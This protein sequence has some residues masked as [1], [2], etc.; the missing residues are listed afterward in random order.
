MKM[1]ASAEP[2]IRSTLL[3]LP[4]PSLCVLLLLS[5][6]A[7]SSGHNRIYDEPPEE[8]RSFVPRSGSR[9]K[10]WGQSGRGAAARG[11]RR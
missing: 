3:P 11:V 5:A 1:L 4:K 9:R 10:R 7:E 8:P 2:W 6:S